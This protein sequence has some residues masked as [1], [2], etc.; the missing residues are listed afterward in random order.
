[1]VVGL[2]VIYGAALAVVSYL[3]FNRGSKQMESVTP[4]TPEAAEMM[5]K[6][7]PKEVEMAVD[8]LGNLVLDTKGQKIAGFEAKMN[9]P[10]S[11]QLAGLKAFISDPAAK[12]ILNKTDVNKKS[13]LVTVSLMVT[14]ENGL[15]AP[16]EVTLATFGMPVPSVT[17]DRKFTKVFPFGDEGVLPIRVSI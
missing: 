7:A 3:V 9:M 14:W 10:Y 17:F 16:R 5:V 8:G 12:I 2:L 15:L 4:R 11:P 13:G 1:M 6:N